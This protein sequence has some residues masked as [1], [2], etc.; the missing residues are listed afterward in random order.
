MKLTS[1]Q[2]I[3]I[4]AL[5]ALQTANAAELPSRHAQPAPAAKKCQIDGHEG[6]VLPGSETCMRVSGYVSAPD[7]L[8]RRPADRG[9]TARREARRNSRQTFA[10]RAINRCTALSVALS[11][12]ITMLGSMPTPCSSRPSVS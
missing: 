2:T 1:V 4:A 5:L 7:G 3:G 10:S 8:R 12:A 11:E 6:V 9:R